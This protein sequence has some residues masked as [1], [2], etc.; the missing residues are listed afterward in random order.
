MAGRGIYFD[1]NEKFKFV[2]I[3][4]LVFFLKLLSV[5]NQKIFNKTIILHSQK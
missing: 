2:D 4:S 1:N 5:T 3:V